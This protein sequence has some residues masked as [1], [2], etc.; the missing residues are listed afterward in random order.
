MGTLYKTIVGTQFVCK[1]FCFIYVTNTYQ[2]FLN[3]G[4]SWSDITNSRNE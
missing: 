1:L 4:R 2:L 3:R